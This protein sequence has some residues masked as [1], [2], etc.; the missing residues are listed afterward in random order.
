MKRYRMSFFKWITIS[1]MCLYFGFM[2]GKFKQD[3]LHNTIQLLELDATSLKTENAGLAKNLS[4]IQAD[5]IA[6]RQN[7]QAL[8]MENK[9]LNTALDASNNKLYFYERVVAPELAVKGLNVYS[10]KVNKSTEADIWFYELVLMQSQQGRRTLEGNV[11]IIFAQADDTDTKT[12][13]IKLSDLDESFQA[14]FKFIYFQTLKGQFTLP[15]NTHFEQV[16]V[17]VEA[18]GNRWNRS[19]RI[20]K[21][22]DWKDFIE[23]GGIEL[24]ELETQSEGE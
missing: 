12:Q 18:D 21:I 24:K 9:D 8:R 3:I 11:E 20:E 5:L 4:I 23:H 16:F 14:S 1:L 22:Y 7:N 17:M 6:E 10:F 15:K 2:V 19:Q 13:P